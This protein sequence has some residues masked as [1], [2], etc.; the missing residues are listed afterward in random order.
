MQHDDEQAESAILKAIS[1]LSDMEVPLNEV[2]IPMKAAAILNENEGDE[3][4]LARVKSQLNKM[5]F[6][7]LL[8]SD[9]P[10]S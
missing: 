1:L 9:T 5:L 3:Q 4:A 10:E 2:T 6:R 8:Y 7:S